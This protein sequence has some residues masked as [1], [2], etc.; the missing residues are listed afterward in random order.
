MMSMT[1]RRGIAA[2]LMLTALIT[3]SV[4]MSGTVAAQQAGTIQTFPGPKI[5][6]N[7]SGTKVSGNYI[8]P[9]GVPAYNGYP[10]GG[11]PYYGS[12]FGNFG[13]NGFGFNN[14]GFSGFGSSN[15]YIYGYGGYPFGGYGGYGGGYTN[16]SG[17]TIVG[18]TPTVSFTPA[19]G[20]GYGCQ[21]TSQYPTAQS[22]AFYGNTTGAAYPTVP[23]SPYQVGR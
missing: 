23:Q 7:G 2:G 17:N 18:C 12:D 19:F 16:L 4:A 22:S 3:G 21:Q 14:F 15:P 6:D 8:A 1:V 20:Y 5:G 10:I 9:V 13:F 11:F